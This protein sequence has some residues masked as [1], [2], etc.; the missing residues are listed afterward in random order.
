MLTF[1]QKRRTWVAFVA[2]V[3]G[4]FPAH[5]DRPTKARDN[6]SPRLFPMKV[7]HKWV[8]AFED[9]EVT[10]EVLRT[11]KVGGEEIFVVRRTIGKGAVEF[12]LS[13]E[14]DGVYIHRESK[15]EFHPPLRQFA[16]FARTGDQWKWR[17]TVAGKLQTEEFE[18]L[19]V[20]EITVPAGT[21]RTISV[22]QRNPANGDQATFWLAEGVGVVKL[23][24]K[25]EVLP[26]DPR[27]GKVIFEWRLKRFDPKPR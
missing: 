20:E 5:A 24:G 7:G 23:S 1:L 9:K 25:S 6:L 17:G 14:E 16:F 12:R 11:E 4:T 15:K 27:G 10:F 3:L 8:Y 18:N 21:Y 22:H 19:G 26:G 2:V 13:V